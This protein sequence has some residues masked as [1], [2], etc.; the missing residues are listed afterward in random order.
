[1]KSQA[2]SNAPGRLHRDRARQSLPPGRGALCAALLSV[3]LFAGCQSGSVNTVERAETVGRRQWV[4]DKRVIRDKFLADK[5]GVAAVNQSMTPGGTL[6]VQLEV[7]NRTSWYRRF[8]Y[9]FEW[10]DAQGMLVNT[11]ASAWVTGQ[12]EGGETK[13]ITGVAPNALCQ[14]FRVKFIKPAN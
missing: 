10:F 8:N 5:L 9:R 1:M 4:V 12:L 11:P 3:F 6:Q 2:S 13:F 7:V 14:D